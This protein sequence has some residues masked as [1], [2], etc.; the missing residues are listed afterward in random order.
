MA[1]TQENMRLYETG[2]LPLGTFQAEFIAWMTAY[3]EPKYG[4]RYRL[5][6]NETTI[7][8]DLE[9]TRQN[10]SRWMDG[11][12]PD[13]YFCRKIGRVFGINEDLV[14]YAAGHATFAGLIEDIEP[15]RYTWQDSR[16]ITS[17]LQ[18]TQVRRWR[19]SQ[20]PWKERAEY[21]LDRGWKRGLKEKQLHDL[22]LTVAIL[23][24]RWASDPEREVPLYQRQVAMSA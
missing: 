9:T 5:F 14:L 10:V 17:A 23:I 16:F 1:T 4:G 13:P 20:S 12:V 21:E 24:E 6:W 11:Y 22:A 15:Y 19:F 18:L 8:R 3:A 7:A 2:R